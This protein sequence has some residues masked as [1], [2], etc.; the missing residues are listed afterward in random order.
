MV[1]T[2]TT[3]PSSGR[4]AIC[5]SKFKGSNRKNKN[6]KTVTESAG[7]SFRM[8]LQSTKTSLLL[9]PQHEAETPSTR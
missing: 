7:W 1:Y 5:L 8:L 2:V 3:D 9:F 6:N 4:A